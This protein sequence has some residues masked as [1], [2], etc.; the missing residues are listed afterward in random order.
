M[1]RTVYVPEAGGALKFAD[2]TTDQQIIDYVRTKYAPTPVKAP[3]QAGIGA[4][5]AGLYGFRSRSQAAFGKAAQAIGLEGAA[6]SL[7]E[8]SRANE[9]LASTY[10]PDVANVSDIKSAGDVAKFAGSTLGQSAT[11]SGVGL[12]GAYAGGAAGASVGTAVFPGPGTV[13]G[14][15]VGGIIGGALASLPGFVGGNLQ[16]QVQERGTTLEEASGYDASMGAIAQ[17]PLDAAVDAL[18]ARKLPGGGA[19]LDIARKGF[20][21]EVAKAA[22]EGALANTLSE[23]AQQAIEIAQANPEKLLEFGPDVQNEILNAAAG[24]AI[25]GGVIGGA[26][27]GVG[28]IGRPTEAQLA[29]KDLAKGYVEAGT[30]GEQM[31]KFAEINAGVSSLASQN[32]IGRLGLGKV[33]IDPTPANGLKAPIERYQ[34]VDTK[35]NRIA[36]FSDPVNAADAVSFYNK[37]SGKKLTLQNFNT[38]TEVPVSKVE[39]KQK[40]KAPVAPKVE[41]PAAE[42]QTPSGPEVTAINPFGEGLREAKIFKTS[43]GSQYAVHPDGSTTRYKTPHPGHDPNDVG[44]KPKS[45]RTFYI[46]S[47]DAA[48]LSLVQAQGLRGTPIIDLY[49]PGVV[50][51]RIIE[52]GADDSKFVNGTLTKIFDQPEVGLSPVEIWNNGAGH[53]FGNKITEIIDPPISEP[54][55]AAAALDEPPIGGIAAIQDGSPE[56]SADVAKA[57]EETPQPTGKL[58]EQLPEEPIVT[59]EDQERVRKL[60]QDRKDKVA[61]GVREALARYNL[62]D[63]QTKFV[64]AFLDAM[65]RPV[66]TEGT[67]SLSEG[68]SLVKLATDIYD[69]NLS[70]EEMVNKVI[71]VLNHESIHSLFDLG[72]IRPAEKAVLMNAVASTK[73][74]GKLYTYLDMAKKVYDPSK[75]GLEAYADPGMVAEEAVAEMFRDW[76]KN[77]KGAPPN[78]RGLFNRI[79]ESL[80][81]MFNVMR[82]NRYEDIFA[83]IESGKLGGRERSPVKG[84]AIKYSTLP[85]DYRKDNPGGDW[86]RGKQESA[87][88]S[89][90]KYPRGSSAKLLSGSVTAYAGHGKPLMLPVSELSKVKGVSD[91]NRVPGDYQ[92][93]ELQKLVAE[94]G[95]TNENP[96]M[97]FV[98]HL[99]QAYIN[100]GNT[101]IAVANAN[102]IPRIA[103]WVH[104]FNG[105]EDAKGDWS[106]ERVAQMERTDDTQ[107]KFS[108]APPVESNAFRAWFAGSK[109]AD[110][111]GQ[112]IKLYTGTSKDTIFESFKDSDRGT[113]VTSDPEQASSYALQNDS[114]GFRQG[115]G[116]DIERTN[117]ASRV[118]P[119]YASVKNILD[120]SDADTYNKYLAD[121]RITEF[122]GVNGYQ[123][124]QAAV[125]RAAMRNGYDAIKWAD[126]VWAVFNPK[127]NL[128]SQFN[129]FTE[130]SVSATKFAMAPELPKLSMAPAYPYGQG[131]PEVNARQINDTL[132][133]ITYGAAVDILERV[134]NSKTASIIPDRFRPSKAGITSFMQKFADRMLPVGQMIDFIKENGGTVPDA[135]DAY[136]AEELMHGKVADSLES[137]E[138]EMYTPLMEYINNS[139]L[140]LAEVEDYLYARHAKERNA[141]M[142]EINP[143]A[144]PSIGSGMSDEEADAI[145]AAVANS[146]KNREFLNA[147]QMFRSMIEDT[148]RL[149]VEAGLTPDFANLVDEEGNPVNVPQYEFYAPL[150]GFADESA[151]D[152]EIQDELRA[153][154]GRGFKIR[155]REDMRAFGRKSKATDLIAHAML[156]NTEAVIRAAKNRVG[157]SFLGLVEANPELSEQFGVEVMTKGKK[158]LKKYISSKG[159]VKTMVDPMYKNSDD[160]MVVKRNGEEIPIR[161]DN[162]F[163]QKAL[164]AKKSGSPDI[165]EKALNTLQ[166]VNRA[167]AAV[168]T[169]YN[170][171]FMLV[172]F[173]RDLQTAVVNITQYEID[174]I[175]KKVLKDALPAV[176]GVYQMLRNPEAVNEWTDWYNMFKQDGGKTSGFFGTFTLDERLKKLEK[177]SQ[178]VSGQPTHR[179]KEAF[180]GIK[181]WLED[182]NA[183]F[184]NAVRL[185]VYKN[186]VEAGLSRQR[187]AQAAKNLTV[188]FDKRGE[189]GPILNSLYLFYNASVQGT[190]SMMMAASRSKKVRK[191]IGGIVVAG[192][193]QDMINSLM[194]DKD[195]DG[196]NIYDKI[197]DYKLQTNMII[198][199]PF[200]ITKNGYYAIPLPYGFN[201]F[202]NMGRTMS[203]TARGEYTSSKA[204]TSMLSTFVDA[205]NPIGGTESLLNFISPTVL[206]PVVALS[207]NQDFTGRKIY[208][209]PFPGSIPKANSQMYWTS[210]SPMFKSTADFLNWATGG[211]EYVPG[212]IDISPD[213]ME[214]MFDYVLGGVGAFGR[215]LY[216]TSTSTIPAALSGDLQEIELNNIP[217][218]RKLYGNVSTRVSMED[219]IDKV[220]HVLT[221]GEEL[222]SAMKEGNLE[223][224]KSVRTR[225]ADEIAI[226]PAIKNLANRRN[227]LAGEL[228]KVRENTKMPPE[229]KRRRQDVLQKQIEMITNRVNK[230]Y[231]DKIGNKYPSLFS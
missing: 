25:A 198:M 39:V 122:P 1:A 137:R 195:D 55:P 194:S 8:Q 34:I 68:K 136:M 171:E 181:G 202:Y 141:R 135:F 81:H 119:L 59:A 71:E 158:P 29:Q 80:R 53:H 120:L 90:R 146:P 149:R 95:Y 191:A 162:P 152:G 205:F 52:G 154:I 175:Q 35:G 37:M 12:A 213:V 58:A 153:R 138:V 17:A 13:V 16:R 117:Q 184:E 75:P 62:K 229:Q 204:A 169:A 74:P 4:L 215:R 164:L 10:K 47:E 28:T 192:L 139:G 27:G 99:G 73:V 20:F 145:L 121:N 32:V 226:Y 206:D 51:V 125:G 230:L 201:A 15:I 85:S 83:D 140:S 216:D 200:G 170:P 211:T 14:G 45:Q 23:P 222:K 179:L 144:D 143:G 103:A 31:K 26:A 70:V 127:K 33:R 43:L 168:N 166:W 197:P 87:I 227:K 190:L 30:R 165:A 185:S 106:P 124:T 160:V 24:G 118:I 60:I 163:L 134:F 217:L 196:K 225:F 108:I 188:N 41:A 107:E 208:P 214:Y 186:L 63:V 176:K 150:R 142:R 151:V 101:R 173:P 112:P 92:F 115:R 54:T 44:I 159:V 91:E 96:V 109:L 100:E 102:G 209:E 155:G 49:K 9:E 2:G 88:L 177:I 212:M 21:R 67:E 114:M 133:H 131:V 79:I 61:T 218:F 210:T 182:S 36:E 223:R 6:K 93:D 38:N 219:Y 110:E 48:N 78:T 3:E 84:P 161:I 167:L 116:W 128:K 221:R 180:D 98:N 22:G 187:A 231:E 224:I 97:V 130:K 5:E 172:N 183:A 174:G 89:A 178:D 199:D 104:W 105:G 76:R 203:R 50:G 132:D 193:M 56:V 113:W 147:E 77:N 86:L 40:A 64:P 57:Q 66:A 220:N 189:Y 72:L 69:P 111:N 129:P 156:Q 65:S 94:S 11:E 42:V 19:A 148:N 123:K 126:N 46:R 207:I 157:Q 82:R 228:R 7:F 18:I